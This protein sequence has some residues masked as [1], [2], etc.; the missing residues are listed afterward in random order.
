MLFI[1]HDQLKEVKNANEDSLITKD[2]ADI[3]NSIKKLYKEYKSDLKNLT[4]MYYVTEPELVVGSID[5]KKLEH[6]CGSSSFKLREEIQSNVDKFI[7]YYA[8]TS[9][10]IIKPSTLSKQEI[11]SIFYI[12][13]R[14]DN[15]T[16]RKF[17]EMF[18]LTFYW[19]VIDK[20]L[21]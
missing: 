1:E 18:G 2:I 20:I 7:K 15:I 14:N 16:K 19:L 4:S 5:F 8:K 12:V 10:Q 17:K 21:K 9:K 3:Y 11:A 6:K 13:V